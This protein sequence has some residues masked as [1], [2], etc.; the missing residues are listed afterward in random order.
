MAGD[1]KQIAKWNAFNFGSLHFVLLIIFLIVLFI[2]IDMDDFT[3]G[4][5]YSIVSYLWTFISSVEYIP[6]LMESRT[7]LKDISRRI[8]ME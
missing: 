3:T 2:S 7:S 8:R 6:E 1:Q 5:I 4:T